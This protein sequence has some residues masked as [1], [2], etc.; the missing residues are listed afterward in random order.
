ML[1]AYKVLEFAAIAHPGYLGQLADLKLTTVCA[2]FGIPL[3]DQA[4][5]AMADIRATRTL[6]K[7]LLDWIKLEGEPE[8]IPHYLASHIDDMKVTMAT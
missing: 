4:H 7:G 1:D 8:E 2:F 3:G 6:T 5:D